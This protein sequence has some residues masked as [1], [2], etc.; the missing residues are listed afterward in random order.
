[1]AALV[2]TDCRAE[3]P[4]PR[5]EA[6]QPV[7]DRLDLTVDTG[8]LVTVVGRSGSGKST[9]L[10]VL[11]GLKQ[12]SAGRVTVDGSAV[13]R[14]DPRIGLVLQHYGLFPWYTVLDNVVLGERIRRRGA[15]GPEAYERARSTLA[16]LGLDGKEERYPRDL[17]GGEQQ[18]VA[19]ARTFVLE[20]RVLLLDEPF[21]ALDALT[22]ESLQDQLLALLADAHVA[23]VM[24]THSIEEAV[25]LGDRVG[26]LARRG[27]GPGEP[28]VARESA[29]STLVLVPNPAPPAARDAT[30]GAGHA[31]R[32]TDA[33]YLS[34]CAAMRGRFRGELGA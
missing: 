12:P 21:S 3:Y 16:R 25:Y 15:P 20:P 31:D 17:S 7:F 8:E 11:S 32:R 30:R 6:P 4:P 24:V 23:A 2:A 34:A 14:G 1:M 29:P 33:S 10:L 22:R 5:G 19:L 9:L 28:S 18:R 27:R 13:G 26:M